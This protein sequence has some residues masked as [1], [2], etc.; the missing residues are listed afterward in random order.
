M[1]KLKG[2]DFFERLYESPQNELV[3]QA[4]AEGKVGVGYNCYVVPE[5]LLNAGN[6][7]GVWMTAPNVDS[8]AQAD[9]YLSA[10]MCSYCKSVL[11]AGIDGTYDFLGAVVFAPT[12]DH[13]RR[14]GQYFDILKINSQND[15]FF[16]TMID[17]PSKAADFTLDWFVKDMKRVA[18]KLNENYN[19]NINEDTLRKSIKEFNEF[20]NLVK[21]IS[22]FRKGDNPKITGTEW[23]KIY[24]ATKIAP[25][26]LLIEP[27]KKIKAEIEAREI[28]N[29]GKLR[30]MIVGS[31]LDK[32]EFTELIE[33]QGCI[34]V[35]DRHCFGS[36]PG[37]ETMD[38]TG[39]PFMTIAKWYLD[40]CQCPRMM[41]NGNERVDYS[42]DIIKEYNVEGVIFQ[43]MIFCDLWNYEEITYLKEL[44]KVNMPYVDLSREYNLTGEGQLRTRIQA[45]LESVSSKKEQA[46]L[47]NK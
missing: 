5:V 20:N 31:T 30:V 39:D 14:S 43:T 23:A 36:L 46:A 7:F 19:S 21:E 28:D 24:G 42:K 1:E 29:Q 32:P 3:D 6:L 22:E 41:E 10:V 47:R 33:A 13:I 44:D 45:F 25:K 26:Y 18:A 27:L 12:C 4:I 2:L 11:E 16:F 37:M 40:T 38:E 34:V 9:Y 15:K 17:A 35:A 8:T